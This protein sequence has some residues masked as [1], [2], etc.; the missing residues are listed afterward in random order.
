MAET[1]TALEKRL[2]DTFDR[3][4][5]VLET[6]QKEQRK[7][8]YGNGQP[9]WDEMLRELW[10][11][12]KKRKEAEEEQRKAD[13]QADGQTKL[14][15]IIGSWQF[16]IALLNGVILLIAEFVEHYAK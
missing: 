11:D 13:K 14:Q 7:T 12:L 10:A 8:L 16:Q 5:Q 15:K 4:L 3:R 9:G 2:R 6:E 1:I